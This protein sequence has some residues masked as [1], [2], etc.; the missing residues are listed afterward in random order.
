MANSLAETIYV[1]DGPNLNS[2]GTLE[3]KI[4]GHAM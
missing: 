1:F 2:V 3:P 4:Y